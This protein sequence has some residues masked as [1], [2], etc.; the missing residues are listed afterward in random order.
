MHGTDDRL[1][2]VDRR[3]FLKIAGVGA[4]ALSSTPLLAACVKGASPSPSAP[5]SSGTP[6]RGGTLRAGLTG[7]GPTDSLYPAAA[8]TTPSYA[9][10]ALLFDA[11]SGI[12]R[13]GKVELRLAEEITP[14]A[15]ASTWTIRL[16]RGVTFH[17]GKSASAEDLIYTFQ[18]VCDPK[19][20]SVNAPMLAAV[21]VKGIKKIDDVTISVPCRTPFSALADVMATYNFFSLLPVGF[22]A[23]HPVGTGPYKYSSFTQ[24]QRLVVAR[25]D[26]YWV[27]GEPYFD[28]VEVINFADETSQ[29]NALLAKQV[30]VITSLTAASIPQLANAGAYSIV[31]KTG[32]WTPIVMRTD[33]APFN[34]PDVVKAVQLLVDREQMLKV[35]F[36]GH[37]QIA[38]D[39]FG[40]YD[41]AYNSTIPQRTYDP[42][43]ARALLKRA[44]AE[45]LHVDMTT[46]TIANGTVQLA[47]V[48]AQQASQVGMTVNVKNI[49]PSAFFGPAWLSRPLTTDFWAYATYFGQAIQSNYPGMFDE[50]H[51]NNK[52]WNALYQSAMRT[53]DEVK[54]ASIVH[55]MQQIEYDSAGYVIPYNYPQIDGFAANIRGASESATGYPLHFFNDFKTMYFA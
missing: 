6:K 40:R 32:G 5:P 51:F 2:S 33:I 34:N 26:N 39:L 31:S 20:G 54:R 35:I 7:G 48:F 24:G 47:T 38:N 50:T 23:R 4:L 15:D 3:S 10:G 11:L 12:N 25:N 18:Q 49:D 37:G 16:K 13:Q 9:A 53:P 46:S 28:S 14:N 41:P 44:G 43:Q 19:S 52:S 8:L 30:D 22:D 21:D 29:L 1:S 36:D 42:D 17:N 45:N 27:S 55:E